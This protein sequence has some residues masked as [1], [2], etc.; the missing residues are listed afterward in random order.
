[1]KRQPRCMGGGCVSCSSFCALCGGLLSHVVT[2]DASTVPCVLYCQQS[3]WVASRAQLSDSVGPVHPNPPRRLDVVG[4]KNQAIEQQP[5]CSKVP[6]PSPTSGSLRHTC[7]HKK[8]RL[9]GLPTSLTLLRGRLMSAIC[10]MLVLVPLLRSHHL[11]T[12][13]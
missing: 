6:H 7:L 11:K 1:M 5:Y 10:Q 4:K 2:Y 13:L 9:H 12:S 3:M 8:K